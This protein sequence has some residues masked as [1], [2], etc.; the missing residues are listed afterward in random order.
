MAMPAK[1]YSGSSHTQGQPGWLLPRCGAEDNSPSFWTYP[2]LHFGH[3]KNEDNCSVK[4]KITRL[5]A[6]LTLERAPRRLSAAA[7]VGR[8]TDFS[9]FDGWRSAFESLKCREYSVSPP[10]PRATP[11]VRLALSGACD[12]TPPHFCR[13]DSGWPPRPFRRPRRP[14][15]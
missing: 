2:L 3:N 4:T 10:S 9:D 1:K 7:W 5:R 13:R 6:A 15:W 8:T 11:S 12:L 14:G